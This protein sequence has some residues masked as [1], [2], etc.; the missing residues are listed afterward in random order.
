MLLNCKIAPLQL[1]M[2]MYDNYYTKTENLKIELCIKLSLT[3]PQTKKKMNSG[4]AFN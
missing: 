2:E 1:C 4:K 3:N